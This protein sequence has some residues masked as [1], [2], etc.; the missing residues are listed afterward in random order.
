MC[1][2]KKIFLYIQRKFMFSLLVESTLDKFL[3]LVF[4]FLDFAFQIL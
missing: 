4:H 1:K 3:L 2:V